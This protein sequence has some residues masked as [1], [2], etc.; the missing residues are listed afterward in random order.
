MSR[1]ES[2]FQIAKLNT[3]IIFKKTS[4]STIIDIAYWWEHW[5]CW[6]LNALSWRPASCFSAVSFAQAKVCGENVKGWL[7]SP[8]VGPAVKH[9]WWWSICFHIGSAST[10]LHTEIYFKSMG[11]WTFP[12]KTI[13][14][15]QYLLCI[16]CMFSRMQLRMSPG[17]EYGRMVWPMTI[18]YG[19]SC[20]S[21]YRYCW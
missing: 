7:N 15:L 20:H 14:F 21:S 9:S 12:T 10:F 18:Y 4:Q 2:W 8:A 19:R 3:K 5:L 13:P 11:G 16:A 1:G 17:V 6:A